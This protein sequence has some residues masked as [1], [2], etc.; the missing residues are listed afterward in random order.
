MDGCKYN[1]FGNYCRCNYGQVY[2]RE[3]HLNGQFVAKEPLLSC[4][5]AENCPLGPDCYYFFN[6]K[7]KNDGERP[8]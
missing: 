6:P 3:H 2:V 5:S 1:V 7:E 4:C 8:S